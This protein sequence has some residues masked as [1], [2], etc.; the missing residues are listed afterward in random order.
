MHPL[1]ADLYDRLEDLHGDIKSALNGLP[2]EA[3]DWVP[4]PDMNS[5]T[6]LVVHT[7]GAERYWIGEMAGG[8]PV[9]RVRADEFKADALDGCTLIKRLDDTLAHSQRTLESLTLED[10]MIVRPHGDHEYRAAWS[11]LHALDHTAVHVGH[12]QMVRQLWDQRF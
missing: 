8:D 11:V 1:F 3:L 10:L 7:T 2:P 5:L 6:V 9:D 4:G 12:I